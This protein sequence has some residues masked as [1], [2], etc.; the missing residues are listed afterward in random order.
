MPSPAATPGLTE[1]ALLPMLRIEAHELARLTAAAHKLA[2]PA[3]TALA[4]LF[5]Q[6]SACATAHELSLDL[7][8]YLSAEPLVVQAAGVLKRKSETE[9]R[10]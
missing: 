9:R 7:Q 8:I 5:G 4:E 6:L 2:E 1:A 3:E 10:R